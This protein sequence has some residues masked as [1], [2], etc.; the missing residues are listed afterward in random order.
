MCVLGKFKGVDFLFLF[1]INKE[2][3]VW[4]LI[5]VQAEKWVIN[6]QPRLTSD[7]KDIWAATNNCFFIME[8]SVDSWIH[9][10]VYKLY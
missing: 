9:L 10:L 8:Q 4:N 5:W 2:K 3:K 1:F 7:L 6:S